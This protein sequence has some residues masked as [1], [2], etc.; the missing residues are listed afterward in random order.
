M[1]WDVRIELCD[2]FKSYL[3]DPRQ[4][5]KVGEQS[6]LGQFILILREFAN[7]ANSYFPH[8]IQLSTPQNL[9]EMICL[10][11]L[12]NCAIGLKEIG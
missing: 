2:L 5:V 4:F 12:V 7:Q 9:I 11:I 6:A 8:M 10:I 3:I 1:D